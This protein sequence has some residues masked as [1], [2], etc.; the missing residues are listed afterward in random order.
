MS[1]HETR[2][3]ETPPSLPKHVERRRTRRVLLLA[4]PLVVVLASVVVYM[5]GGRYVETDNAY[6]QSEMTTINAEVSGVIKSIAVKD[7]NTVKQGQLLFRI[8]DASFRVA[9]AKAQAQRQQVRLNILEQKAAYEEKK[10]EIAQANNLYD[11]NL[12]EEKRQ[13]NLLK[14]KYISDTQYDQARQATRTSELTIATLEKDLFRLKQALGG[15][16]DAALE[17]HPSYQS[18][19]AA[20]DQARLDLSHVNVRAPTSG[21][22]AKVP[23]NGEY[24][25]AGSTAMVLVSTEQPWI[26]ANFTEK[27]LAYVLPGQDVDIEIDAYPD[28]RLHGKVESISPATGS[29]F[30]VI[31][32]ENATG[33]WVKITQRLA[34]KILVETNQSTP[35]LRS[36]FSTTVTIDTEH[37]RRLFGL[38]L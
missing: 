1:E 19:Q 29:E 6:I 13:A 24:V 15:D 22:V 30:S 2:E 38:A 32:A 8:D 20:L 16:P 26:E 34:V 9:E 10:A 28:R 23:H 31:P 18:A 7:N 33:N 4:L 37:Q 36:G 5:Q 3:H 17:R 21:V 25:Q 11:Y 14:Q 12:R 27:D 35:V